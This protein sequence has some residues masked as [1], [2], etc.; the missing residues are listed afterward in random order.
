MRLH[1]HGHACR[2]G[3][4]SDDPQCLD[5]TLLALRAMIVR[6]G[7]VTAGR[8]EAAGPYEG[9]VGIEL[10][11]HLDTPVDGLDHSLPHRVIG[12]EEALGVADGKLHEVHTGRLEHGPHCSAVRGGDF[13]QNLGG[14]AQGSTRQSKGRDLFEVAGLKLPHV[15]RAH[16]YDA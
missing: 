6:A 12:V 14:T 9:H 13:G 7:T 3:F 8:A 5:Q 2:L 16:S 4:V 15:A 11:A 1:Y 10:A